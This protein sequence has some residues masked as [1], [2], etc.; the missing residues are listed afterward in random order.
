MV[1]PR[2][3]Y[4]LDEATLR[5]HKNDFAQCITLHF[6]VAVILNAIGNRAPVLR[7]VYQ[8]CHHITIEIN[9]IYAMCCSTRIYELLLKDWG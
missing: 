2:A 4:A 5:R 9:P 1:S 6:D 7:S 8:T 3:I